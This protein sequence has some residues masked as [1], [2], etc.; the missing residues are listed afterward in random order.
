MGEG[1][2]EKPAAQSQEISTKQEEFTRGAP[3]KKKGKFPG[4]VHY[5]KEVCNFRFLKGGLSNWVKRNQKL[6]EMGFTG[7]D[8]AN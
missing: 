7:N 4:V 3:K 1:R 6:R 5:G 8:G 2:P